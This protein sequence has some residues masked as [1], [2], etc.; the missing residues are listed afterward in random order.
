MIRFY[1]SFLLNCRLLYP[2]DK[3]K[4]MCKYQ[5]GKNRN[6]TSPIYSNNTK[7][8]VTEDNYIAEGQ[9]PYKYRLLNLDKKRLAM[10]S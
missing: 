2:S 4:I 7:Q 6:R 10:A 5:K 3:I 1:L 8:I 9:V